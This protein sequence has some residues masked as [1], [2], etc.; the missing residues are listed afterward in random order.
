[1][2]YP[3]HCGVHRLMLYMQMTSGVPV[4]TMTGMYMKI[5][6]VSVPGI[7]LVVYTI[8]GG[9]KGTSIVSVFQG[10]S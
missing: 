7:I 1:M 6:L 10:L 8:F 2:V 4:R 5:G 9:A 3:F